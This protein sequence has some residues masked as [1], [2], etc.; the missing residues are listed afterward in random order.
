MRVL[1]SVHSSGRCSLGCHWPKP[2]RWL[3]MRS[4]ARAF[5]SSRRAP[6]IRQSKRCSLDRFQQRHRLVAVARF[7]RVRQ[8]HRA[9]ADA[10][11][12]VADHQALAHLGD[13]P[14]AEVDDFREVVAGVDVQQREGQAALELVA[15][16]SM[17][18]GLLG[19]AQ[20]HAGILATGEEQRRA[21]EA[22]HHL[23]QDED[24]FFLQ[25]VQVLL[26]QR[27]QQV[28]DAQRGVHAAVSSFDFSACRPHSLALVSSHHQRPARKSSPTAMARVH[29]A[30]PTLGKNWSCSSL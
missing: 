21:L 20:H 4:L 22:G 17:L 2:S 29:G 12:Q 8:A 9:A 7:Q 30:Q 5:S 27:G 25:P 23:A 13:A 10:V 16:D 14:V 28:F 6:P 3:K 18:E 11:V 1:N 15:A 19:Q 26:V 24:G